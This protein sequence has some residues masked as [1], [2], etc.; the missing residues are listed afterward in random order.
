MLV[1]LT[2]EV[3][4]FGAQ[5]RLRGEVGNAE[6]FSLQ[7]AKPL[8]HLVHPR[9][10]DGREME[11]KSRMVFQPSLYLFAR[12]HRQIITDDMDN[13][14]GRT[15]LFFHVRE[16]GNKLRLAFA[17]G[18]LSVDDAGAGIEC[19]EKLQCAGAGVF[20][21]HKRGLISGTRRLRGMGARPGLQRSLFVDAQHDFIVGQRTRIPINHVIYP[22]VEFRIPRMFGRQPHVMAPRFQLACLQNSA[23][24]L[25]RDRVYQSIRNHLVCQFRTVPL[26]ERTPHQ[27]RP[28]ASQF[29]YMCRYD[30][31]KKK[32]FGHDPVCPPDRQ[33]VPVEIDR[34]T[35]TRS[36]G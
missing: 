32:A 12:V 6:S 27:I 2:D 31:L 28:L 7:D 1:P 10:V 30:W 15:Y 19:R 13:I 22:A 20:V 21:F 26:R 14:N 18:A 23:D 34:A 11:M 25:R 17:L 35:C 33:G 36:D 16:E 8:L 29:R 5:V 9:T 3:F 24:G 4:E